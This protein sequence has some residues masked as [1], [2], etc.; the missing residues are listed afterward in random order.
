MDL[1]GESSLD[2][3]QQEEI[4]GSSVFCYTLCAV[5]FVLFFFLWSVHFHYTKGYQRTD[6]ENAYKRVRLYSVLVQLSKFFIGK[7]KKKSHS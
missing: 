6:K 2:F 5:V 3:N 4:P 1:T 7:L